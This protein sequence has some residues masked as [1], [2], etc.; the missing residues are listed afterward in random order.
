M[1]SLASHR[2]EKQSLV[3]EAK[4]SLSIAS[5]YL[6]NHL[7]NCGYCVDEAFS[8]GQPAVEVATVKPFYG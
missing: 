2:Y 1:P 7:R 6:G 8:F 4:S 3:G 5:I